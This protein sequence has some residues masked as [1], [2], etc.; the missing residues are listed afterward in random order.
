MLE[1]CEI[2]VAMGN[3][4]KDLIPHAKYI[5]DSVQNSGVYQF[6]MKDID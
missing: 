3:S 5:T 6:F 4:H 2:G 1:F